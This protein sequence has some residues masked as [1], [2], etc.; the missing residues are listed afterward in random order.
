MLALRRQC[1]A[2]MTASHRSRYSLCSGCLELALRL[3]LKLVA[4]I[5]IS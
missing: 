2:Y 4:Y 3:F 1:G 5:E